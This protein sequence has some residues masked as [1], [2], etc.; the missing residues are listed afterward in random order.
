MR[1]M[2]H[3]A[4]VSRTHCVGIV[5]QSDM[6]EIVGSRRVNCQKESTKP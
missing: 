3:K 2:D 4:V 6:M 1:G 5:V